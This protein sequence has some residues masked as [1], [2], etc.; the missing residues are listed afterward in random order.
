MFKLLLLATFASC[1]NAAV[2]KEE[3]CV[4]A[5]GSDLS[6]DYRRNIA[7]AIHSTSYLGLPLFNPRVR[8]NE[9]LPFYL[10]TFMKVI[11]M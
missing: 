6:N 3:N 8:P 5:H 10:G 7:H 11:Q 2:V 9:V 4:F 1:F